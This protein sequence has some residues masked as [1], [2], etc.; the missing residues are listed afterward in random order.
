MP[1][2]NYTIFRNTRIDTV[3]DARQLQDVAD[4]P[5]KATVQLRRDDY[6]EAALRS[7]ATDLGFHV[8]LRQ[9]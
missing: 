8:L 9:Q 1:L 7:P 2:P 3:Q 5:S 4:E 6:R